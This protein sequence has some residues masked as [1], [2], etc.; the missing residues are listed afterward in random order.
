[1][2]GRGEKYFIS[3]MYAI[4]A[5]LE[6]V[7]KSTICNYW[8]LKYDSIKYTMCVLSSEYLLIWAPGGSN[9]KFSERS[10]QI[11]FWKNNNKQISLHNIYLSK[12]NSMCLKTYYCLKFWLIIQ[13]PQVNSLAQAYPGEEFIATGSHMTSCNQGSFSKQP[14]KNW[15]WGWHDFFT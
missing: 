13:L 1:M 7:M 14:R 12:A 10:S 4:E 8:S 6:S 9:S 11:F 3:V 15:E 5:L 2:H